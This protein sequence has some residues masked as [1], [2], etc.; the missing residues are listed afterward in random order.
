MNARP[1]RHSA[2]PVSRSIPGAIAVVSGKGGVGKTWFALTLAHVL[3]QHAPT[4]LFDGDLGLANIDVQLGLPP[5]RDLSAAA[6]GRRSLAEVVTVHEQ[7]GIH[8]I[9]GRSGS[10]TLATI[11]GRRLAALV[12]QLE[13]VAREYSH[14]ILDLG[15]GVDSTVRTLARQAEKIAVVLTEEPTSL[16]DAYAFIKLT[17]LSAPDCNIQIV[18]NQARSQNQGERTHQILTR[19][20]EDFLQFSPP[21]L[22]VIRQDHHVPD[23]IR[24]QTPLLTRSPHSDAAQD[25]RA[26]AAKVAQ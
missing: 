8:I 20:C 23:T 21:L 1:R 16:T 17:H 9:A 18:V 26:I 19:A 22:G 14:T 10:S 2:A 6:T 15:A 7:T 3:A 13:G 24:A 11:Q 12:Q 5:G 4:L 25:V